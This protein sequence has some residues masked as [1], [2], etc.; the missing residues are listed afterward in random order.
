MSAVLHSVDLTKKLRGR[1]KQLF[2]S[3]QKPLKAGRNMNLIL[4][5]L[6][7]L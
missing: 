6:M 5:L 1:G 2:I 3:Y 4:R 7:Q